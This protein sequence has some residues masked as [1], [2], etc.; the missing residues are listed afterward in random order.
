M[1]YVEMYDDLVYETWVVD[2]CGD[3]VLK[4]ADYS[5]TEIDDYLN[6]HPEYRIE[7]RPL[8]M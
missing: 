5:D 3:A 6:E 7:T 4:C 8:F 2:E 1:M